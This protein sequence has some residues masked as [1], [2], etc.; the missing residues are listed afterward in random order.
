M[1]NNDIAPEQ[2]KPNFTSQANELLE[3][4]NEEDIKI[5][6]ELCSKIDFSN[7]LLISNYGS[8][9]QKQMTD[10]SDGIL[11]SVKIKDTEEV[12]NLITDLI[13]E[14]SVYNNGLQE[15]NIF[16]RI[17]GNVKKDLQVMISK[18]NNVEECINKIVKE[19]EKKALILEKDIILMEGFFNQNYDYYKNLTLYIIAGKKKLDEYYTKIIPELKQKVQNYGMCFEVQQLNDLESQINRFE[20]RIYDLELTRQICIQYAPQIRIVQNND[21]VLIEK[22]KSTIVNTIPLWKSGIVLSLGISHTTDAMRIQSAVTD[23]TNKLLLDNAEKLKI[24]TIAIAKENE[25]GII[26]IETLKKTNKELIDTMTE[27]LEIQTQGKQARIEAEKEL[28][29]LE[30]ELKTKLLEHLELSNLENKKT[31]HLK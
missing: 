24:Q 17:F 3:N 26:D 22:I 30:S 8:T 7:P 11:Q 10:F 27:V 12:G 28:G 6:D 13:G 19:L 4:L 31:L 16:S 23:L 15:K 5:V 2:S 21:M 9:A 18:Y 14:I 25:R 1:I 20:K 29:I